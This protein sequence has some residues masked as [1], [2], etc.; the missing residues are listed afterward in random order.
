MTAPTVQLP[1][2]AVARSAFARLDTGDP[3]PDFTLPDHAGR[4]IHLHDQT[5]AGA[6]VAIFVAR[7][8]GRSAAQQE[9]AK[10]ADL[11]PKFAELGARILVVS[12]DAASDSAALVAKRKL[13]FSLLCD[14]AGAILDILSP[15]AGAG[16]KGR[17]PIGIT[18]VADA[19]LR[20]LKLIGRGGEAKQAIAALLVL[21]KRADAVESVLIHGQA[22]VLIVPEVLNAEQCARL[23]KMWE[24][25][26]PFEG[27]VRGSSG[28]Y[29]DPTMK[30][31]ADVVIDEPGMVAEIQA[32]M[33]Q[34]VIPEIR[35]AFQ[36]QV[37]QH[38]ALRV[39]CYDSES[40]GYFRRHRDDSVL[41][42]SHRRFAMTMNLNAGQY[43]GGF[44]K[45]PEYGP[46]LYRPASGGAVVFSCS[47]LHEAMPV[48]QGRRFGMF[49]FLYGDA[50]A[51]ALAARRAAAAAAG[52]PR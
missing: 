42:T 37:T 30:R 43:Q 50:E 35:K 8:L 29:V 33:A 41:E 7:G 27:T 28:R 11:Q 9:L 39:G 31:R 17:E 13:P 36:H 34:R 48:T 3:L 20:I 51:K 5:I 38:E 12:G 6:P 25:G 19:N 45:F 15:N 44:L 24:T 32:A 49:T 4:P 22:P 52:M 23:I 26:D 47:L 40:G 10:F 46:Y 1:G 14:A 18:I 2:Q 21:Q 16:A